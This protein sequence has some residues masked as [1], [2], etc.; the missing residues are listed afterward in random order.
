MD[1][2]FVG[3]NSVRIRDRP[4]LKRVIRQEEPDLPKVICLYV[5]STGT[6]SHMPL[7]GMNVLVQCA[8]RIAACLDLKTGGRCCWPVG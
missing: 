8:V 7:H 4:T 3:C 1:A 5:Q 6:R 2:A